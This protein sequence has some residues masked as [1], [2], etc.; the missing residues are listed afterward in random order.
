MIIS[1]FFL[2]IFAVFFTRMFYG[3]H[4]RNVR[5]EQVLNSPVNLTAS[6]YEV[7]QGRSRRP[8]TYIFEVNGIVYTG[9]TMLDFDGH[10]GDRICIIYNAAY[11]AKNIYCKDAALESIN[12]DAFWPTFKIIGILVAIGLISGL[13]RD[14]GKKK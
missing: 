8:A 5:R 14:G 13:R 10:K 7:K 6:V 12:D 9:E 4:E 11:P 1:G 3:V 2:L